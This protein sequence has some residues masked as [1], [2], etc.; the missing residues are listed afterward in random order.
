VT[1]HEI[2]EE[3]LPEL[4]DE[5]AK[6][7]STQFA[8]IEDVRKEAE[9]SLKLRA[10]EN[11]RMNFEEKII[12][13]AVE[14]AKIEYPPVVIDIE[15]ERI[16]N[17]Q[18]RQLQMTGQGMDEYL[19]S[20]NKTPQQLVDDLKPLAKRN[21][22]ASLVLSQISEEEKIEV[23]E[24]EIQNGISNMIRSLGSQEKAD[25]MRKLLDTPKTR[26]SLTQS[27]KTRKTIERLADIAK[28]VK[29]SAKENKEE[30][31]K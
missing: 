1:L 16:I 8:T 3:K 2:K 7:I 6:Q 23:T 31:K 28:D 27:I 11:A 9:K 30:E 10:E 15:I 25:E 17:E 29:E 13:T 12:N 21:V 22:E 14:Q 24:E 5:F 4:N 19:K 26:Q 20:I 18:A